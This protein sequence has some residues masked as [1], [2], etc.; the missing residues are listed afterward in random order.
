MKEVV[1]TL[2]VCRDMHEWVIPAKQMLTIL[3]RWSAVADPRACVNNPALCN[4]L[5]NASCFCE[6][7]SH[8][9]LSAAVQLYELI[10]AGYREA[11]TFPAGGLISPDSS[12]ETL[13]CNTGLAAK[14]AGQFD[15][16]EKYYLEIFESQILQQPWNVDESAMNKSKLMT[17]T[18][19]FDN[20]VIV[21]NLE[22]LYGGRVGFDGTA[23]NIIAIGI[24]GTWGKGTVE[25]RVAAL[26]KMYRRM[27]EARPPIINPDVR[28]QFAN[29]ISEEKIW[30]V[31]GP[32]LRE[33]RIRQEE[34]EAKV[35]EEVAKAITWKEKKS[36]AESSIIVNPR[37]CGVC[38]KELKSSLRCAGCRAVFYCGQKCQKVFIFV[39]CAFAFFKTITNKTECLTT[40]ITHTRNHF[41]SFSFRVTSKAD[42]PSHRAMCKIARQAA[43]SL[44]K[45][46][47]E[48]NVKSKIQTQDYVKCV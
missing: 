34:I 44:K 47:K 29:I 28:T 15:K 20:N 43:K 40:H 24:H 14:R 1:Y 35:E 13:L 48:Q 38:L 16:A 32:V 21:K 18:K 5:M 27:A 46:G 25:Y 12:L 6:H 4:R 7:Q 36:I 26:R 17:P 19:G 2:V 42:W 10:V 3:S 23:L 39:F 45:K 30:G 8:Q 41:I 33:F 11:T 22:F 9:N 31:G 37:Q